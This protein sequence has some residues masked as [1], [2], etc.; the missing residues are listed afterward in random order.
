[1]PT[2]EYR[3]EA[4]SH[5]WELTQKINDPRVEFCTECGQPKAKRLISGGPGKR[6]QLMGGGW[7]ATG[8]S[9]N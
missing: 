3:C 2:Y 8:Y 7:A 9:G 5:E 1:M 4:C 6:F